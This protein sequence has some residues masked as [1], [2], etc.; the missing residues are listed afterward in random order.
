MSNSANLKKLGLVV[1]VAL[2]AW[3]GYY[4]T[5]DFVRGPRLLIHSPTDGET[6]NE[7]LVSISG[8]A[9]NISHISLNGR[10][11]FVDEEGQ[12]GEELLLHRGYNII[13]V[14]VSDKYGRY[15]VETLRLVYKQL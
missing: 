12:F 8:E 11:I 1:V 3:Y 15:R 14:S 7:Q 4:Q 6:L 10:K 13:T 2:L 5:I 9:Q